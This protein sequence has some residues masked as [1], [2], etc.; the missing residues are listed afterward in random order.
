MSIISAPVVRNLIIA[1]RHSSNA[2]NYSW[3]KYQQLNN[4]TLFVIIH[5]GLNL[6]GI[7]KS[8]VAYVVVR[9]K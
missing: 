7:Q 3:E 9:A 8:C 2:L 6:S 4:F 5:S 1:I